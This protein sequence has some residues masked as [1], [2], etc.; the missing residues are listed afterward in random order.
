MGAVPSPP[1]SRR[2]VA[3]S[4]EPLLLGC[5]SARAAAASVEP[6][7][8]SSPNGSGSDAVAEA[9]RQANAALNVA[10]MVSL[11]LGPAI[12]GALVHWLGGPVALVLNETARLLTGLPVESSAVTTSAMVEAPSA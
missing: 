5:T 4:N 8:H 10:F 11:W 6:S 3:S 1:T 7:E 12:G 2:R 9:Q